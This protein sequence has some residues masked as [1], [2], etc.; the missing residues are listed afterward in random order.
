MNFNSIPSPCYVVEERKLI[1]NLQLLQ[2]V[3]RE[4]AVDII[5]ALKGYSLYPTFHLVKEYLA[6]ATAS[7]LHEARL[8]YEEMGV[9]AHTYCPAYLPH[10]FDEVLRYS[11][12]I[13]FNS[14]SQWARFRAQAQAVRKPLSFGLRINPQYSEVS[15]D[16]YNPAIAGSRLG[17]TRDQLGDTL[18]EGIHGLHFHTL[19]EN[20]SHTLARTLAAVEERFGD[21]LHQAQ[22]LNMGGGHLI[23]QKDYDPEHLIQL[24][25]DFKS[26]YP[27]LRITLEPGS[28]IGWETGILRSTVLDV[29]HS[30]GV[31]VAI[32]DVSVANHMPD[33]LEMPYK[34]KVRG[35]QDPNPDMPAPA[36]TWRLGGLTC[37][38][39]DFVGDYVFDQALK[40]GDTVIFE[41]MI[42][43]T[44][45][46]TTTFNGVPL[47]SIGMWTKENDFQLFKSFGYE[48]Y[49]DRLG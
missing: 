28:A 13:T 42:H 43:Y 45:V 29:M 21:M 4:A 8:I 39:G 33:C 35:A 26:R 7:S 20:D 9:Q 18:P 24:L 16:L 30:Q 37:L 23:T 25:K 41:D 27:H 12:H 10:E 6:G 38:A 36:N 34:P 2:R 22:W 3:Q 40:V 14:L 5:L 44:L 15:T 31:N 17:I 49:K 48:S 32:L 47:P 46:K 19:C 1:Q 11:S